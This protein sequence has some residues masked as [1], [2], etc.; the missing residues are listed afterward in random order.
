MADSETSDDKTERTEERSYTQA[1]KDYCLG[2]AGGASF[3]ATLLA[4]PIV[5]DTAPEWL[6][7][8]IRA[9][10][11]VNAVAAVCL[12]AIAYISPVWFHDSVE[13]RGVNA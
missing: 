10:W 7:E 5:F 12:I 9:L 3:I 11:T 13:G 2:M 1:C 8:G 4:A 6:A